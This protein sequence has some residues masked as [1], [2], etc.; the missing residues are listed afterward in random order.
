MASLTTVRVIA[1]SLSG[2]D[3]GNIRFDSIKKRGDLIHK[4]KIK[5]QKRKATSKEIKQL[6]TIT[7]TFDET[8]NVQ[9]ASVNFNDQKIVGFTDSRSLKSIYDLDTVK[10]T[11]KLLEQNLA[12]QRNV[13]IALHPSVP[14]SEG[15]SFQVAGYSSACCNGAM[16]Y[17]QIGEVNLALSLAG[18][19]VGAWISDYGSS[20]ARV[21]RLKSTEIQV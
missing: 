21:Q 3:R 6:N 17:Q 15:G 2:R 14:I 12:S 11:K 16:I 1:S 7:C 5:L 4:T 10:D 8:Y 13:F 18:Y 20:N 9:E 19:V